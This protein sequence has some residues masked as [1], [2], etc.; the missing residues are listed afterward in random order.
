MTSSTQTFPRK[1]PQPTDR[2]AA[3]RRHGRFARLRVAV[4][5]WRLPGPPEK[6]TAQGCGRCQARRRSLREWPDRWQQCELVCS[7]TRSIFRM[8]C[9]HGSK[10]RPTAS[11]LSRRRNQTVSLSWPIALPATSEDSRPT[12][13][14]LTI[15]HRSGRGGDHRSG[16]LPTPEVENIVVPG[17]RP[18]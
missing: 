12:I 18:G 2:R 17:L 13:P 1:S 15:N 16:H 8:C 9:E 10:L 11:M 3:V 5:S 6:R 14:L 4:S 7:A